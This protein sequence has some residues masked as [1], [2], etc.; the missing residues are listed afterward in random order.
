MFLEPARGSKGN[1]MP[2]AKGSSRETVST[3]I[4]RLMAEGKKQA[5]A[6]AIS[7]RVAGAPGPAKAKKKGKGT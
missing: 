7:L 3:N 1:E 2:L 6:V 5:Q 4:K